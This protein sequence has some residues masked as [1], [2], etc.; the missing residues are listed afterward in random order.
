MGQAGSAVLPAGIVKDMP[1]QHDRL[2]PG[3]PT[4]LLGQLTNHIVGALGGDLLGLY[5]YGSLVT[6]DFAPARSDLDLLAVLRADPDQTTVDVLARLHQQVAEEHPAWADRIEVEYLS[7]QALADFRTRPHPAVRISPGEPLHLVSATRHHLLNW[8]IARVQ[9]HS[10]WGPVPTAVIPEIT[11]AEFRDVV[12]EHAASWPQWVHDMRRPGQQAYAVL[13]ICRALHSVTEGRQISKR[14]AG[15]YASEAL[16][17]WESLIGW[18]D[19]WW[20]AGGSDSDGGRLPEVARFVQAVSTRV[21]D[22]QHS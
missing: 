9:G 8:Y 18:A 7:V 14:Q 1:D 4:E 12:M 2:Q 21:S 17:Q 22:H 5:A 20:Y 11:Q 19:R 13:T 10:L 16:P 6:G 3:A 15:A